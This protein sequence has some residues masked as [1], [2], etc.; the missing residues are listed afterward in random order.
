[1]GKCDGR[2]SVGRWCSFLELTRESRDCGG[3]SIKEVTVELLAAVLEAGQLY[4]FKASYQSILT[5][6]HVSLTCSYGT[7]GL[8]KRLKC[9]RNGITKAERPHVPRVSAVQQSLRYSRCVSLRDDIVFTVLIGVV[10]KT[11]VRR[12]GSALHCLSVIFEGSISCLAV[13]RSCP[14]ILSIV[15]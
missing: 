6:I 5:H 1:M 12:N 4:A 10:E 7:R 8:N 15:S 3:V 2:A 9:L 13:D 11:A 14:V